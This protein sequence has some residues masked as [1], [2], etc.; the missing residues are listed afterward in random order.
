MKTLEQI[1][2]E[3]INGV[4]SCYDRLIF[5]GTLTDQIL[6]KKKEFDW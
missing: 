5:T 1:Y 6:A 4:L 3:K 2:K